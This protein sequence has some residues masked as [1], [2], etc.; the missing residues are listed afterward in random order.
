MYEVKPINSVFGIVNIYGDFI[1]NENGIM[2]FE[3]ELDAQTF[4]DRINVC[5]D[6]GIITNFI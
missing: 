1:T 3:T 2:I 6:G 4:C 5:S